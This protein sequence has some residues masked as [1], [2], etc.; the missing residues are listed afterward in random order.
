M[1]VTKGY[2]QK[3]RGLDPS[4]KETWVYLINPQKLLDKN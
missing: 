1:R 2:T 4:Y 3:L